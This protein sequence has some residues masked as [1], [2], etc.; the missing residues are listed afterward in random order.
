MFQKSAF[1]LV[2]YIIVYL[3]FLKS[4]VLILCLL[5]KNSNAVKRIVFFNPPSF[6]SQ[7]P[8]PLPK[9]ANSNSKISAKFVGDDAHIV[10]KSTQNSV[11]NAVLSVPLNTG[12]FSAA[13]GQAA[14][15]C[16]I[17]KLQSF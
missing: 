16:P 6:A 1:R 4:T 13:C 8:P 11:G 12:K 3:L 5:S 14:L 17:N 7:N 10:P 2:L 15:H 9:E